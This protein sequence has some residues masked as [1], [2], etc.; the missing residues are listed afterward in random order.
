MMVARTFEYL[1]NRDN[2]SKHPIGHRSLVNQLA[3]GTSLTQYLEYI[4]LL[5]F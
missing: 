1:L 5:N 3:T 4:F 2:F